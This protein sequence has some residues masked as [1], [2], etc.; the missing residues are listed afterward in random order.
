MIY[1]KYALDKQA[2]CE[3]NTFSFREIMLQYKRHMKNAFWCII[4]VVTMLM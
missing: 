3:M 2:P 4:Y 1:I